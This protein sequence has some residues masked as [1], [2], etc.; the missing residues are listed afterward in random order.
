LIDHQVRNMTRLID[1]LIDVSRITHGT[2]ELKTEP[3]ELSNALT[4]AVEG[5]QPQIQARGQ[6]LAVLLAGGRRTTA[7]DRSRPASTITW[8]NPW[9]SRNSANFWIS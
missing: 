1:D 9:T 2:I 5:A 6:Q 3:V 8:S 7:A 4:E